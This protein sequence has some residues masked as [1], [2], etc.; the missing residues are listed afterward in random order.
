[1]IARAL[2]NHFLDTLTLEQRE[3]AYQLAYKE[4]HL[5]LARMANLYNKLFDDFPSGD[6][7]SFLEQHLRDRVFQKSIR[8]NCEEIKKVA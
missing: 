2:L 8:D 5:G 1:M 3:E 4:L 7:V 6:L